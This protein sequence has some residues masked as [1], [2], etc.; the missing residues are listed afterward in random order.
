[1]RT[2]SEEEVKM[3]KELDTALENGSYTLKSNTS[4]LVKSR[5]WTEALTVAVNP[6]TDGRASSI[7]LTVDSLEELTDLSKYRQAKRKEASSA[8]DVIEALYSIT[9]DRPKENSIMRG[10]FDGF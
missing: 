2:M 10:L 6:L 9:A 8:S 1:M 3:S 4:I 7:R 5:P